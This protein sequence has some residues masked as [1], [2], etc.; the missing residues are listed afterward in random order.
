MAEPEH[1][2]ILQ[3]ALGLDSFGQGSCY[4]NHFV[5]GVGSADF[6]ACVELVGMGLMTQAPGSSISGGD[7]IFRVTDAGRAYAIEHSPE[8]P[9][10]TR[11]QRRYEDY[12]AEDS[13][14]SFGDWLRSSSGPR[15]RA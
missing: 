4:R 2:R 13:G 5:T 9:K 6:P 14:L 1:L 7:D 3:H 12:L 15:A 10:L 11:S 8:P